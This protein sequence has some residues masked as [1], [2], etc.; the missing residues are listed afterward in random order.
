MNLL[1]IMKLKSKSPTVMVSAGLYLISLML[2]AMQISSRSVWGAE[3]LVGG[4]F[5]ITTDWFQLF[6]W[7]GNLLYI[8]TVGALLFDWGPFHKKQR[9]ACCSM[10]IALVLAISWYS[11][12]TI[13]MN[14]DET[15]LSFQIGYYIWVSS[16]LLLLPYLIW[17][18]PFKRNKEN[19]KAKK[20]E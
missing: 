6:V 4:V 19:P 13:R 16:F 2:P 17:H 14:S 3:C 10:L 11:C 12:K 7:Y 20:S 9:M 18:Y 1:Q 8:W 5:S 15:I